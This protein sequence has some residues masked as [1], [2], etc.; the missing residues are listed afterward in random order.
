V[1]DRRLTP[2]NARVA[3]AHLPD[4]APGLTRVVGTPRQVA[5]PLVD[6]RRDP[7]GPRERQLLLGDTVTV[8]EDRRGWSFVQAHRDGHVGYLR[9]DALATPRIPTDWISA[10]STHVYSGADIK[11]PDLM[12]LSFGAR[13][14]ALSRVGGFVETADGFIPS[15]H[16]SALGAVLSDPVETAALFLGTP[17]LWGGNSRFGIDCSGLVQGALLAAGVACPGDSD[18]QQQALGAALPAGTEPER[19]DLIFWRGHVAWV[20]DARTILHA[21]AFHMAVA[22]ERLADAQERIV[23]QG[24]GPVTAHLRPLT[25]R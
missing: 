11:S 23:A 20:V 25:G 22:Y 15:R 24:G 17:Y 16:V 1:S 12:P 4:P 7:D 6:L 3:A 18:L 10:P 2:A 21:N 13:I 5:R 19:N 14:T 9:S 8:Y